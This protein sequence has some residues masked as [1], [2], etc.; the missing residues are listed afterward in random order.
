[1]R[2]AVRCCAALCLLLSLISCAP[3]R[4]RQDLI[5]VTV[6]PYELLL[7][8]L[9]GETL[10]VRTL[11]P[12]H[13]SPHNWNPRPSDLQALQDASLVISNGLDLE[14]QLQQALKGVSA[15]H[16]CLAELLDL[17]AGDHHAHHAAEHAKEPHQ[18]GGAVNPHLWLSPT[19]LLRIVAQLTPRLQ[20]QWPELA[21]RIGANAKALSERLTGLHQRLVRERL[22]YGEIGII[23]YHDSFH[24]FLFDYGIRNLGSV[25]ASP[26]REPSAR[27]LAELG[28]LI[29]DNGIRA[30]CVE[31]QL[32]RRSA[33]VLAREFDLGIIEL[34]PLGATLDA[35]SAEE[36]ILANW[37]RMQQS[38]QP[39][40]GAAP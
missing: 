19:L 18:H 11:V 2:I 39:L 32:D 9:V 3:R 27:Q 31:P 13:A 7:K 16:L 23:T 24:H 15:K 38:W 6:H 10:A 8:E 29:R 12:P 22:R 26:S 5:L 4:P 17:E 33:N 20:Q 36:L 34:D 14:A 28:Q 40:P 25:Q 35:D 1:M 37:E 21:E 30:I